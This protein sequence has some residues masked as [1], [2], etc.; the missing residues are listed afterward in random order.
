MHATKQRSQRP[1]LGK[2][3]ALSSSAAR[4]SADAVTNGPPPRSRRNAGPGG[5]RGWEAALPVLYSTFSALIGTQSVLFSKTLAV[6]LRA[7]FSGDNQVRCGAARVAAQGRGGEGLGGLTCWARAIAAQ[8]VLSNGDW[9]CRRGGRLRPP[10]RP[11]A[12]AAGS[13]RTP[14]SET[15]AL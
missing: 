6:L 2:R 8:L 11:P 4:I 15:L 12:A 13:S 1:M 5:A 7:T 10:G 9:A 3:H 14:L